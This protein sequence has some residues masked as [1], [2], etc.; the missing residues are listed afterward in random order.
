MKNRLLAQL[1]QH[2]TCLC[3]IY[4]PH[5]YIVDWKDYNKGAVEISGAQRNVINAVHILNEN[6]VKVFFDAFPENALPITKKKRS[7]QCECV[8]FPITCDQDEWILFIETKYANS[9]HAAKN[10]D[11]DYPYCM[12]RQIKE[13]VSYFRMKG[14]IS[15]NKIL[16][17]ILAFP[18]LM[19]GFNSWVFPIKHDGIEES[20]LDIRINDKI[21]IRATNHAQ[22]VDDTNILL[23]S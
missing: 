12:V 2:K 7:R 11:S 6:N 5:L 16:H 4:N 14:I 3:S 8:V 18:N 15:E 21:I 22:I 13:T 1:P 19:E 10:P 23:L 9:I 17:A 20:I